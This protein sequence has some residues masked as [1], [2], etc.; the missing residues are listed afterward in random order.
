MAR[1]SPR[2][3]R[4]WA[5]GAVVTCGSPQRAA[6]TSLRSCARRPRA[7]T[8]RQFL[9]HAGWASWTHAV[10]LAPGVLPTHKRLPDRFQRAEFL[11]DHGFVDMVVARAELPSTLAYLL[12]LHDRAALG[13]TL[14]SMHYQVDGARRVEV[15][16]GEFGRFPR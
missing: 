10:R 2:A 6:F 13:C 8:S 1:P 7:R 11:L 3:G 15:Y 12:F 14:V 9:R 16:E 4:P 5:V